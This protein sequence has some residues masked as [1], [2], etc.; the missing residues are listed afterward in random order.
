MT[1]FVKGH[2]RGKRIPA[3]QYAL[4]HYVASLGDLIDRGLISKEQAKKALLWLHLIQKRTKVR[5]SKS[6]RKFCAAHL[7]GA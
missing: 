2:G 3:R 5:V 6:K 4:A 7:D 1:T